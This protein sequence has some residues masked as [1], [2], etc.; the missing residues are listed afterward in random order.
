M[1]VLVVVKEYPPYDWGGMGKVVEHIVDYSSQYGIEFTIIANHPKLN[2]S[3]EIKNSV[4]IYRV[5]ALGSTFLTKVPSFSYYASKLISKL[6]KQFDLIYSCSSPV[7]CK[8]KCPFIVHLHGTR[9]GEYLACKLAGKPVHAFLNKL[10]IPF[11]KAL[12]KKAD[13]I[14]ILS[15]NMFPEIEKMGAINKEIEVIPNGV[16]IDLFRPLRKYTPNLFEKRILYV[17]RLDVRKGIDTLFY[18]FREI[19]KN[20]KAKLI[21][22]GTGKEKYNL[23][24]LAKHLSIPVD[25]L[26]KVQHEDLPGIYNQADLFVLPSLYE[27]FPLVALEAMA[28]GIP[29]IVSDAIPIEGIPKFRKGNAD[30]LSNLLWKILSSED[31]LQRLSKICLEIVQRFAWDKIVSQ[32]VEFFKKFV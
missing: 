5:P 6:Q 18:A 30:E 8:F 3:K 25:F 23:F 20:M 27:A 21:I 12:L 16:D 11:D 22:A 24:N 10:Y 14:I 32:I 9:L 17:G 28:C 7:Y 4:T 19:I 13:G 29:T 31:K 1:K 15:K 2:I 26:G